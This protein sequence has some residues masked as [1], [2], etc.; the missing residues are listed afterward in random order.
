MLFLFIIILC[1]IA[2]I[3]GFIKGKKNFEIFERISFAVGIILV[4]T[5]FLIGNRKV[6][7]FNKIVY[8]NSKKRNYDIPYTHTSSS[9]SSPSQKQPKKVPARIINNTAIQ[10]PPSKIDPRLLLLTLLILLL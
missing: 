3:Y 1:V 10:L 5:I 7:F 9:S 6:E 2:L 8:T 4:I